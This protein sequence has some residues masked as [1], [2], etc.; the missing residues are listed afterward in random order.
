MTTVCPACGY[1]KLQGLLKGNISQVV[2]CPSCKCAIGMSI[3]SWRNI[4]VYDPCLE[5]DEEA[6][7][8]AVVN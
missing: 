7:K 3:H 4:V 1:K 2:T 8:G 5:K 6:K